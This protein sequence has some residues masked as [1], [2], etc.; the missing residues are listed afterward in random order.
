MLSYV[1]SRPILSRTMLLLFSTAGAGLFAGFL[2]SV[3]LI[4]RVLNSQR[5]QLDHIPGPFLA[6]YTDLWRVFHAWRAPVYKG[7]ENYQMRLVKTYGDIVRIGPNTVLVNDPD[8]AHLVLG[9]KERLEK[10]GSMCSEISK[11]AHDLLQGP[12][13]RALAMSGTYSATTRVEFRSCIDG[14]I[15]AY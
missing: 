4:V 5:A 7:L 15:Q 8:A 12:G 3:A 11:I 10:V 9:F 2:L 13:Y 1:D 6:K 14:K